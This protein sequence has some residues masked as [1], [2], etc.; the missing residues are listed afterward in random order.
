MKKVSGNVWFIA[1]TI[2]VCTVL[3]LW[4]TF[5]LKPADRNIPNIVTIIGTILTVGGITFSIREQLS[6]KKTSKAIE[7]NTSQLKERLLTKSFDWNLEKAIKYIDN[8]QS[9]LHAN[10]L[11]LVHQRLQD[12]S[13]CLIECQRVIHFHNNL[14]S[15]QCLDNLAKLAD[16]ELTQ[17]KIVTSLSEINER[18]RAEL[19]VQFSDYILHVTGYSTQI[20]VGQFK[21]NAIQN[22]SQFV[23]HINEIKNF[24]TTVRSNQLF[25]I[26]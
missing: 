1:G 14:I 21:S 7:A 3:S 6:I 5:A 12:L 4:L 8:I 9:I 18:C 13:E 26:F 11:Y 10:N 19:D 16:T 25:E 22:R 17:E 20:M 24:L 15:R 23:A 2:F